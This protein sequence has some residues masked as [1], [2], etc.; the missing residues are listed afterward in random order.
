E[1]FRFRCPECGAATQVL[2]PM[3]YHD[4]QRKLMI[5]MIPDDGSGAATKPPE[6]PGLPTGGPMAG[7]KTR[8]VNSVNELL[9]KILIF[10]AELDDLTLEMIKIIIAFQAE[11]AGQ[12][13]DE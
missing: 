9:E 11:A 3:L 8:S 4:M 13:K 10:D 2:Y 12:P 6:G 5:W 7:Y 1:L